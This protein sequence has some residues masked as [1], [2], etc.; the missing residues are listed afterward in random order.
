[1]RNLR[2]YLCLAAA[3]I[4]LVPGASW[5]QSSSTGAITGVVTDASGATVPG[6]DVAVISQSTG[7]TARQLKSS[8]EG[9]FTASFLP[10]DTYRVEVTAK[11]F[12]KFAVPNVVVRVT[13]TASV[14]VVLQ[15]GQVTTIVTVEAAVAPVQVTSATTG[16]TIEAKTVGDLPMSTGNFLT[17]LTLSAGANT[18]LFNNASLGRGQVTMNINGNRPVNNNYELEGINANDFN[19]PINDNVPLPNPRTVEEFKA[20]TSLYDASYGRNGGG[21]TQVRLKSGTAEYHGNAYEFFRNDV[22]NANDWF[23]NWNGGAGTPLARP[24]LRQNQ[25]GGTL[26][27]PVPAVK[28]FFFFIAYQG[29]RQIDAAAKTGTQVNTTIPILPSTRT[30]ANLESIFFPDGLPSFSNMSTPGHLDPTALAYLTLPAKLCP[31]FNDG[32]YCIPSLPGAAGVGVSSSGA[33]TVNTGLL[34]RALPGRF[35]DDQFVTTVDKQVTS[36]DKLTGRVFYSDNSI[37]EPFGTASSLP[38]AE[39]MPGSNRFIEAGWTRTIG[40]SMVNNARFG[41]SRYT[42]DQLPTEPIT[43]AAIDATRPNSAQFPAAYQLN[44]TG[45]GAFSIGTGLN[46]NRG[47]AFNT[48][49]IGDDFSITHGN[50]TFRFGGEWDKYQLNRFNNYGA[51]GEVTFSNTTYAQGGDCEH[52]TA[53][54][55]GC[56][57]LQNFLLGRVD[58]AVAQVGFTVN[59]FRNADPALY[60]QDDWKITHRLT[61]NLGL[62]WEG[63]AQAHEVSN[64]LSNV[65]GNSDGHVLP[66]M[67]YILPAGA[68]AGLGTPGVSNCTFLHCM[69]KKDFAPRVGF[70]WDTFGDHKTVVSGGFGIFYDRISNQSLLQSGLG[71]PFVEPVQNGLFSVP[72]ENPFP[73]LA[74]LSAFPLPLVPFPTLVGFQPASCGAYADGLPC[75]G[76]PI[77]SPA[78]GADDGA[79][80]T[81][82]YYAVR[83][84][85]APYTEQWNFGIQH[86]LVSQW[87]LDVRYVGTHGV[88]LLGTGAPSNPGQICTAAAPCVIPASVGSSVTV[89]TGTPYVTKNADGSIDITG[90]TLANLDARSPVLFLGL[91]SSGAFFVTQWGN[92]IY[93]ALQAT[94]S[95][96]FS[97]GLY[98]QAAYTYSHSIDNGSGSEFGDELNG[99]FGYGNLLNQ[100]SQRGSADFDRTHRFVA[101]YDYAL[102]FG[103]WSHL[104]DSGFLGRLAN[105]WSLSGVTTFQSG[106]PFIVLDPSA[107]TLQDLYGFNGTNFATFAPGFSYANARNPGSMQHIIT[108]C[109]NASYSVVSCTDPTSVGSEGYLNLNAFTVGGNCVSAQNVVVPCT[110]TVSGKPVANPAVVG[111]AFGN[112]GRNVFRGPFQQNWDMALLKNTK[113]SERTSLE[114]RAEAFNLFNHPSFQSPQAGTGIGYTWFGNYGY[115]NITSGSPILGTVS[116]ARIL[117]LSLMLNF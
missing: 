52:T 71:Y 6:A 4:L 109:V 44:I 10:P 43:L 105:G 31:G 96:Q 9:V 78:S 37:I 93:H 88:D 92:S 3:L 48:F 65:L 21:N 74:P 83:N 104:A 67:K 79:Y 114:F 63:I 50:H 87:V 41:F 91:Q 86:E 68:P 106:T 115:D 26:G 22:F 101:S 90:S 58:S 53:P 72:P 75:S 103:K 89:P 35:S 117:Q 80:N 39:N 13:E 45:G 23:L 56:T 81:F 11:G 38:F 69:D 57:G 84:L 51:R 34:V 95:H 29:T 64:H 85:H 2:T 99:N 19:L 100:R 107:L 25:F 7:E 33:I 102:P 55:Q 27:G 110:I 111:A 98:F 76:A 1:M 61:L 18:E 62:R 14:N 49:V 82:L 108:T 47:G 17:L 5:A 113:I 24:E 73:S 8:A 59:H 66:P 15:V 77:F 12:A 54:G 46:D 70:A 42:F 20:Q 116:T 60:F 28:N 97:K 16:Q 32:K 30:E 40:A 112:V 36:N 94:L